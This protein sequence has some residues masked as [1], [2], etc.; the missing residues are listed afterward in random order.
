MKDQ[1]P[2]PLRALVCSAAEQAGCATLYGTFLKAIN[3]SRNNG[4]MVKTM[5][6]SV[7]FHLAELWHL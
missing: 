1:S 7:R 3:W 2:S 4:Q 5:T 6:C